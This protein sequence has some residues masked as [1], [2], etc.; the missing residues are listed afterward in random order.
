MSFKEG[1]KLNNVQPQLVLGLFAA[2]SIW[3]RFTCGI[4]FV[5]TSISDGVHKTGSLHYSGC[6][7]DIRTRD[8][9]PDLSASIV[10]QFKARLG[11]NFDI[12]LEPTHIHIE[13][14]PR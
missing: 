4:P 12:V 2:H 13:Y 10:R 1:V 8:L 3:E 7:A 5:I 6:A 11:E 14:D 9:G